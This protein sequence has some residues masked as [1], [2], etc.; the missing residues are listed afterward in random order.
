MTG[1]SRQRGISFIML[2]F[3]V[4]VLAAVGLVGMQAFPT[5]LEYQAALKAINKSK[6]AGTPQEVRSLFDR[7]AQIDNITA[8][9]GKD[10]TIAK[11]GD[12]TTVSFGYDKEFHL[13]GPAFLV[14]KYRGSSRP[15]R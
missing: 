5:V 1:K 10:L 6:E 8:I 11:N 13:F 9:T 12:D 3:V 15:G 2:I 4:A 14:L 7:A